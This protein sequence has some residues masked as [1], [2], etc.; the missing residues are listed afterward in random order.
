M[1]DAKV[2]SVECR[3]DLYE[4][5]NHRVAA[6]HENL[7]YTHPGVNTYYRNSRGRV[8]VQN[9][10]SNSEYWRMTRCPKLSD[11]IVMERQLDGSEMMVAS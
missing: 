9:A 2:D 3:P 11:Y 1:M 10:F 7:I 5:Y 8:V 4:D 6:A